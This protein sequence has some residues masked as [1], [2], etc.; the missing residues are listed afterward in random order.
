[1]S[2]QNTGRPSIYDDPE[3]YFQDFQRR[4]RAMH[5]R[6]DE[7]Q[8][9][10]GEASATVQSPE[11]EV[12]VTASVTGGLQDI[13]FTPEVRHMGAETLRQTILATYREAAEL[14]SQNLG[15]IMESMLGPDSES[16]QVFRDATGQD[17]G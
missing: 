10:M 9:A 13:R 17:R 11:G 12:A 7:L 3:G 2:D 6:A 1:M 8:R 5:E 4:T 14:A 16:V 15:S